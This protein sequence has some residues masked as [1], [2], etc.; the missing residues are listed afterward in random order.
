[1]WI[2][3]CLLFSLLVNK[4]QT[5]LEDWTWGHPTNLA[6][7]SPENGLSK[8]VWHQ[9]AL[10]LSILKNK[11][12]SSIE[13]RIF[14]IASAALKCHPYTKIH[15]K[16]LPIRK[17]FVFSQSHSW[18]GVSS[19]SNNLCS[20]FCSGYYS[21][22]VGVFQYWCVPGSFFFVSQKVLRI[23]SRILNTQRQV[24][25]SFIQVLSL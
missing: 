19:S 22:L 5:L 7:T 17:F 15:S 2:S 21:V 12:H 16:T 24:R 1:M 8:T 14:I 3:T 13:S 23:C 20:V 25:S 18:Y 11:R 9:E 10:I 6:Q 4:Q